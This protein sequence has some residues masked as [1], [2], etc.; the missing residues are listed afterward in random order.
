MLATKS[1]WRSRREPTNAV[2]PGGSESPTLSRR[3]LGRWSGLSGGGGGDA[4]ETENAINAMTREHNRRAIGETPLDDIL[5]LSSMD[6]S[7][8]YNRFSAPREE[9]VPMQIGRLAILLIRPR[10]PLHC[11]V[12]RRFP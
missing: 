5:D 1:P 8:L 6:C 7:F 10:I 12:A 9:S 3:G 4:E 2:T 11:T